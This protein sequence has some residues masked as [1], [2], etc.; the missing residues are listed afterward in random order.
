MTIHVK[1]ATE[2]LSGPPVHAEGALFLRGSHFSSGCLNLGITDTT[3]PTPAPNLRVR[4]GGCLA[5]SL[6]STH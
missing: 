2:G 3:A 1:H 4:V 5:A 6:V